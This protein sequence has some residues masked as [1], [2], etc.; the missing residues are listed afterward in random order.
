MK[1]LA[2][3]SHER[4]L[5]NGWRNSLQ[6]TTCLQTRVHYNPTNQFNNKDHNWASTKSELQDTADSYC[7]PPRAPYCS[8]CPQSELKKVGMV[9]D[10]DNNLANT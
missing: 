10:S 9:I 5:P 1:S 3:Q 6:T 2:Q 4:L 8:G 7:G